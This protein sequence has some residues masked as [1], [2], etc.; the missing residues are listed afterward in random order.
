MGRKKLTD[1]PYKTKMQISKD[2]IYCEGSG[3]HFG[4]SC[5]ACDGT[6]KESVR[7]QLQKVYNAKNNLPLNYNINQNT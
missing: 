1:R 6:G 3:G 5:G 2:C 4:K 7:R